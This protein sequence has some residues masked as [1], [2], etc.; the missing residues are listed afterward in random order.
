MCGNEEDYFKITFIV[1]QIHNVQ[2][3]KLDLKIKLL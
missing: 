1:H 2:F 3:I